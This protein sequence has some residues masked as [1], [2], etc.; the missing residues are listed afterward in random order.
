MKT[1]TCI[2]EFLWQFSV[3]FKYNFVQEIPQKKTDI[4]YNQRET[5]IKVRLNFFRFT[6]KT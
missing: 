3:G 1:T 4:K 2:P 6:A 5:N